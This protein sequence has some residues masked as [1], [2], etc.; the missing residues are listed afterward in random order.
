MHKRSAFRA[1][2]SLIDAIEAGDEASRGSLM[3][4]VQSN[5]SHVRVKAAYP[6]AEESE[7]WYPSTV[8]NAPVGTP[9]VLVPLRGN[10]SLFIPAGG[11][12]MWTTEFLG[13]RWLAGRWWSNQMVFGSQ[14]TIATMATAMTPNRTWGTAFIA[15][16]EV[17]VTEM[18]CYVSVAV[19]DS[20]AIMGIFD[21]GSNGLATGSPIAESAAFSTATTG[22]KA[23]VITPRITL[24]A[25]HVY[26]L[27]VVASDAITLGGFRPATGFAATTGYSH[28]PTIGAYRDNAS[29]ALI[30][31]SSN[32]LT[33]EVPHLAVRREP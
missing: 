6:D 1:V 3:L 27:S 20:T 13:G 16:N 9:G 24:E 10:R 4:V 11:T 25:G 23:A 2:P 32:F 31:P 28:D 29:L 15:P 18:G 33:P 5:R 22:S 17:P 14:A 21:A 26:W 30:D 8:R 7:Q 19:A 12:E